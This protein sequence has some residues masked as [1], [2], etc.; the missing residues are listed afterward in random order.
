[1]RDL[2]ELGLLEQADARIAAA[3]DRRDALT[4]ATMRALLDGR[5]DAV[6]AG[7]DEL[8]ALA[9]ATDDS[10]ALDRHWSQRLWAALAW[11]S[12]AE[13]HDVLDRC[14]ERAYRFD[15]LPWWGNLTLLLA[16]MGKHDESVRAFDASQALLAGAV[17]DA[18]RLDVVTNLLEAAVLLGDARRAGAAHRAVC[19]PDGRLVV[20]GPGVV[21]KGSIERYRALGHAADGRWA[22]AALCFAGAEA[23]HRAIG[24]GPLLVRTLQQ[25]EAALVAD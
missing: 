4:W 5:R 25:A 19:S 14:R 21:C 16:A 15:D 10:E 23:V 1:V 3:T 18:I 13:R 12:D 22:E 11:G 20:A 17:D 8:L 6:R 24:A 9:R 7:L 2:L